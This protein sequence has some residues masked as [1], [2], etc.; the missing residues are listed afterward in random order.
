MLCDK[1]RMAFRGSPHRCLFPVI[2]RLRIRQPLSD[3]VCGEGIYSLQQLYGDAFR[4][5][6]FP[7]DGACWARAELHGSDR[8]ARVG[9]PAGSEHPEGAWRFVRTLARSPGREDFWFGVP[10]LLEN[11]ER[12]LTSMSTAP[13]KDYGEDPDVYIHP[14]YSP[15]QAESLR[16]LI[17]GTE[18]MARDD[19]ALLLILRQEADAVLSGQRSARSAAANVQSRVSLYVA[20]QG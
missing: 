19:E 1:D 11:V 10:P 9:I 3:N 20:E 12:T 18:K 8:P 6:S 5:T 2:L 15:A 14:V 13:A 7:E 17:Y 4:F 16:E